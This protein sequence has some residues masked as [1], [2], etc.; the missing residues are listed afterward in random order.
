MKTF[1][2]MNYELMATPSV[3]FSY[4]LTR[5]SIVSSQHLDADGALFIH[6]LREEEGKGA[7]S[8]TTD[9]FISLSVSDTK[10]IL[11]ERY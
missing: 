10:T 9:A 6:A 4:E 11:L 5:A 1:G 3:T 7:C 2:N 8:G